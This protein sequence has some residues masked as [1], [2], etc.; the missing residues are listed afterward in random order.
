MISDGDDNQSH[1]TRLAAE[2][3]AQEQ[4]VSVFSLITSTGESRGE[5]FMREISEKTGGWASSPMKAT[6]GVAPVLRAI[7]NQWAL[8]LVPSQSLDQKLHSLEVKSSQKDVHVFAPAHV[9]IQ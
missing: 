3:T 4:G 2:E 1:V 5:H 8:S 7:E 9:S 6:D